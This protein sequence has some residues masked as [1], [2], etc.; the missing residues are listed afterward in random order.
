MKL[1]ENIKGR[2]INNNQILQSPNCINNE[3]FLE[4]SLKLSE[5]ENKENEQVKKLESINSYNFESIS[6]NISKQKP[7]VN[8]K[9]IKKKITKEDLNNIPLPIFSCIYCSNEKISFNHLIT[10]IIYNKYFLQTS[11]YDMKSLDEIIKIKTNLYINMRNSPLI[12]LVIKSTEFIRHYYN[13]NELNKIFESKKIRKI[14]EENYNKAYC[15]FIRKLKYKLMIKKRKD[16]SNNKTCRNKFFLFN[17]YKTS[18]QKQNNNSS[19]TNDNLTTN[20][21]SMTNTT[22]TISPNIH[23][24][25]SLNNN[26][27]DNGNNINICFNYN[28]AMESIMEKIEKNEESD[29]ESEE[30]FINT[31]L[32]ESNHSTKRTEKNKI[33]FEN[34]YYDIWNPDITVINEEENEPNTNKI[35]LFDKNVKKFKKIINFRNKKDKIYSANF[36]CKKNTCDNNIINYNIKDNINKKLKE[37]NNNIF[38]SY[39]N[40]NIKKKNLVDFINYKNRRRFN[41][42][43]IISKQQFSAKHK[44]LLDILATQRSK[45]SFNNIFSSQ[46]QYPKINKNLLDLLKHKKIKDKNCKNNNKILKKSIST[47]KRNLS[48]RINKKFI[49]SGLSNYNSGTN[50]H[51]SIFNKFNDL[52]IRKRCSMNLELDINN[53]KLDKIP[54]NIKKSKS[55]IMNYSLKKVMG[56]SSL[57]NLYFSL[58]P[59]NKIKINPNK[60][61]RIKNNSRRINSYNFLQTRFYSLNNSHIKTGIF[62]VNK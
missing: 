54:N 53:K 35:N 60:K 29:G 22:G 7:K 17:D 42:V 49:S 58:S 33:S 14:Y 46:R 37:N 30:K 39:I 2:N 31:I 41:I 21:N 16:F 6:I 10:E 25:L 12:N 47:T 34:K 3:Y 62:S 5:I 44:N 50:K 32:G 57:P 18:F 4:S 8:I 13:K 38:S 56:I 55:S 36:I 27:N 19:F 20:K 40:N 23:S 61:I 45:G 11:I 26:N 28:N 1:K 9:N 43:S 59:I 15:V 52:S 24:S 51:I 48:Q